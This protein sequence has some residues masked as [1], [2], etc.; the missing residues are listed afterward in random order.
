MQE[1]NTPIHSLSHDL[2]TLVDD[3]DRGTLK[4]Q[5]VIEQL[6]SRGFGLLLLLF[7]F[8]S[9]LP[10][11]APGYSIPFGALLLLLGF[12]LLLQRRTPWFPMFMLNWS[13]PTAK[14]RNTL[15][16]SARFFAML[17]RI[18]KPRYL[19]TTC[20]WLRPLSG[21][22]VCTM[23]FLMLFPIPLTNT[24]PAIVIFCCGVGMSERDGL[25]TLAALALGILAVM[26]YATIIAVLLFYGADALAWLTG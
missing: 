24:L 14:A 8:P 26:L 25:F 18:V 2:S 6:G 5:D 13:I 3:P 1:N 10:V 22:I 9:A 19:W 16:R 17:E 4:L 21:G 12:Q 20:S 23:A 11:P 15:H 7:S